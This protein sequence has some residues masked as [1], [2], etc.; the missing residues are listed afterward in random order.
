M[1][2]GYRTKYMHREIIRILF[3]IL[4]KNCR[5]E[6]EAATPLFPPHAAAQAIPRYFLFSA[7]CNIGL[8]LA[9]LQPSNFDDAGMLSRYLTR[10]IA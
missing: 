4:L 10:E 8:P 1:L 6:Q 2:A 5:K 3:S 7:A 9:A